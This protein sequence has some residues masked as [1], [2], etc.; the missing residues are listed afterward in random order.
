MCSNFTMF[1]PIH[2]FI[3][4]TFLEQLLS[5]RS[6]HAV[7]VRLGLQFLSLSVLERAGQEEKHEV[8]IRA[9]SS[10]LLSLKP[11]RCTLKIK[12]IW[13]RFCPRQSFPCQS[14]WQ[15]LC[16]SECRPRDGEPLLCSQLVTAAD[17]SPLQ[18][19]PPHTELKSVSLWLYPLVLVLSGATQN[20]LHLTTLEIFKG[21]CH[22]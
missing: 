16:G 12:V 15:V 20:V 7:V 4:S 14:L 10:F 1:T 5:D 8:S 21:A 18:E 13:P 22:S 9:C 19:A 17:S 2:S 11:L 6:I 3:D